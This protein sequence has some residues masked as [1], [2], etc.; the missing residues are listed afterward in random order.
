MTQRLVSVG[1]DYVVE[2][3]VGVAVFEVD[4]K[5][6]RLRETLKMT[7]LGA[8]DEYRIQERVARARETMT[9][10]K[11][12]ERAATIHKAVVSPIRDRFSVSVP[13]MPTTLVVGNVL[14]YEY[15][16]VRDGE[17]IAEISKDWFRLRDS[18][19]IEVAPET[20]AGVL[21]ACTVA[22]DMMVNP[23]R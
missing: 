9:V 19:G 22:L 21:I 10:E 12:G 2:N 4:G 6:L 1:D 18:Y 23:K 8:G 17:R 13:G 14:D 16:M 20:D 15:R 7:D 3:Q 5:A 11:N